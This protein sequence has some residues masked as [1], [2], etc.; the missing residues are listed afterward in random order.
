MPRKT[1]REEPGLI[2]HACIHGVDDDLIFRTDED[3]IGFTLMLAATVTR[4]CWRCLAYCQMGTH[5]HLLI[6]TPEPNLGRGMQ[7][8]NGR[9]G[10][11][12][13][14][15]CLRGGHLF[16]GRYHDE[17]V[18]TEGHLLN[19]V[20]YIAVN[21]CTAG[22]CRDPRDW[23][24]SSHSR[25]VNGTAGSWLAHDHLEA[26]LDGIAGRGTYDRLIEM[27]MGA[28]IDTD[29]EKGSDPFSTRQL[30]RARMRALIDTDRGKGSD[31]F[32]AHPRGA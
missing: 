18:V 5:A 17:P 31:P 32:S 10:T 8:L 24:W 2:H 3:R 26:L 9:Y 30:V 28:L 13:N 29:Q 15:T 21:P 1:R 7:W 11:A 14:K 16:G 19:A 6:Q 12:F 23:P 22:L 4:Y 20:G 27:R 25:V